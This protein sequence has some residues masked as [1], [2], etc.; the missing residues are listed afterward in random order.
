MEIREGVE[1]YMMSEGR[2]KD[3]GDVQAEKVVEL[4]LVMRRGGKKKK[5]T[6]ENQWESLASGGEDKRRQAKENGRPMNEMVE[7]LAVLGPEEREKMFK[8][9]GGSL[10]KEISKAMR[11]LGLLHLRWMVKKK[12]EE[13]QGMMKEELM[14]DG[15]K[16]SVFREGNSGEY[17]EKTFRQVYMEDLSTAAGQ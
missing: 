9:Y 13:N 11:D 8:W 12:I 16:R 17:V 7:T 15:M 10:P 2:G 6:T 14:R 3:V 5:A 1:V 4:G